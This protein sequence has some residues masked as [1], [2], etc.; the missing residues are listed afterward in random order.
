MGVSFNIINHLCWNILHNLSFSCP[1]CYFP[2]LT[3]YRMYIIV[4]VPESHFPGTVV[5]GL[6]P[7]T[8]PPGL[9]RARFSA[10]LWCPELTSEDTAAPGLRG[11]DADVSCTAQLRHQGCNTVNVR[12]WNGRRIFVYR[13]K[14][15]VLP[16]LPLPCFPP[17]KVNMCSSFRSVLVASRLLNGQC[18]MSDG[19]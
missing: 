19:C 10:F 13:V 4:V 2:S 3:W 8:D 7:V 15:W 6:R 1:C 11:K 12:I 9:G 18:E 14:P 5:E 16:T 17:G